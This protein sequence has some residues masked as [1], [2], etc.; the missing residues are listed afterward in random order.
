MYFVVESKLQLQ[1]DTKKT[2]RKR[3]AQHSPKKSSKMSECDS[4]ARSLEKNSMKVD[5]KQEKTDSMSLLSVDTSKVRGWSVTSCVVCDV[6][7]WSV[8]SCF[9][10][11]HVAVNL[12]R[13]I[14]A[15]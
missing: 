12:A 15:E 2:P 1:T 6:V 4:K 7:T 13:E 3:P 10:L 9:T 11:C 8:T 14:D 5:E